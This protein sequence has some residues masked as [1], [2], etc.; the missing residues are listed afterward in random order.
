M[1]C[2]RQTLQLIQPIP[3]LRRK[4]NVVN[5]V[6]LSAIDLSSNYFGE[7]FLEENLKRQKVKKCLPKLNSPCGLSYKSFM[8][9][10][11]D[12]NDSC[13]LNKNMLLAKSQLIL[14]NLALGR[15]VNYNH[16]VRCKL[17]PTLQS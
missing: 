17:K 15:S 16:K 7:K 5:M 13:L 12:H 14:A 11:C 3:N 1:A 6:I 9:V 10:T 2:Q 4:S 8:I